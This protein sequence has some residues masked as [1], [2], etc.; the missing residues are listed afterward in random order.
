MLHCCY[1]CVVVIVVLLYCCVVVIVAFAALL[2]CC[3]V[4][5]T[6][7]LKKIVVLQIATRNSVFYEVTLSCVMVNLIAQMRLD[8]LV[9]SKCVWVL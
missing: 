6:S 5:V 7:F 2:Y 8:S 9:S 4:V 1:C 3:V